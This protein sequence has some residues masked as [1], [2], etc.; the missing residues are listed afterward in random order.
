MATPN[1]NK[2]DIVEFYNTRK[3]LSERVAILV[4]AGGDYTRNGSFL[5]LILREKKVV[6]GRRNRPE[7]EQLKKMTG[8]P[9]NKA[10]M[11]ILL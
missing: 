2:L 9:S 1:K 7:L 3:N 4:M 6:E 8:S 11:A 5:D 10:L